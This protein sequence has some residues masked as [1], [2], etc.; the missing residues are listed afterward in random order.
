MT[1]PNLIDFLQPGF[2]IHVIKA[3]HSLS[4]LIGE[5]LVYLLFL[6]LDFIIYV[7]KWLLLSYADYQEKLNLVVEFFHYFPH[8]LGLEIWFLLLV[9]HHHVPKNIK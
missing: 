7:I 3:I 8:S 6:P 5:N 1:E 2:I 4:S 9:M